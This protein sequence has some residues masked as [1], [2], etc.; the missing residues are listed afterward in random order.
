MNFSDFNQEIY[1]VITSEGNKRDASKLSNFLLK[2]KLI[3]CVTFKN[4]ESHF[5]WEGN[6]NKLK[7]VQLMF[8]CK[9]ENVKNVCDMIAQR[10]S[11]EVPEIICFSVSTNKSYYD[12]IN[13]V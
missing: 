12:W 5:W 7:E 13:C 10:H 1:I 8:K 2:D 11:Y 4:V 3:S 6:I 9:K